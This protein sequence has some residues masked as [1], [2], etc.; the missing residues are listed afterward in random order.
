MAAAP[1][2]TNA[3]PLRHSPRPFL[4]RQCIRPAP[5]SCP[6]IA[7][8]PHS[9]S[10]ALI[11][12]S[13]ADSMDALHSLVFKAPAARLQQPMPAPPPS[14]IASLLRLSRLRHSRVHACEGLRCRHDLILQRPLNQ[15]KPPH[16]SNPLQP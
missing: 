3:P 15:T 13:L 6:D 14:A 11:A 8:S 7:S 2:S 10:L 1:I 4:L 9:P 16:T 12:G 5:H